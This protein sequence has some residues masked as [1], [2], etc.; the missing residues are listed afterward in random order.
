MPTP[1][2]FP[3][4]QCGECCRHIDMIPQ[5][6]QFDRGDGVCIHLCENLCNIYEDRPDI[7]CVDLK[8]KNYFNE[9]C[10][11]EDFYELNLQICQELRQKK[12][13]DSRY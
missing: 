6:V 10:T 7:C 3:C 4:V 8:Y 12:I 13:K 9:F 2:K 5:L 11:K 1:D